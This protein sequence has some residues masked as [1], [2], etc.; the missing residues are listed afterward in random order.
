MPLFLAGNVFFGNGVYL[1][2][3]LRGGDVNIYNGIGYLVAGL[4]FLA[5]SSSMYLK[6]SDPKLL[7][8]QPSKLKAKLKELSSKIKDFVPKPAPV[9]KPAF[10]NTLT[11]E[12]YSV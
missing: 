1:T 9:P 7:Q 5:L 6:D 12:L 8:K 2:N 10:N 3:F 4:S 11:S